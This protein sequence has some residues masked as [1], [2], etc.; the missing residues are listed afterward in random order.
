MQVDQ[1]NGNFN[2]L[3]QSIDSK[4]YQVYEQPLIAMF[5]QYGKYIFL[6]NLVHPVHNQIR[7][8]RGCK[9]HYGAQ[10]ALYVNVLFYYPWRWTI[11][12]LTYE[13]EVIWNA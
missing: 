9:I 4:Y 6:K 7:F 13:G 1:D 12:K 2:V 3:G 8:G 10:K 11:I 5:N